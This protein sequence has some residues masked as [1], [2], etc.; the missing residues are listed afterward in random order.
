[1]VAFGLAGAVAAGIVSTK[2]PKRY[3]SI[4]VLRGDTSD[5]AKL[6]AHLNAIQKGVLNRSNLEQLIIENGLYGD[7][8]ARQPIEDILSEMRKDIFIAPVGRKG[9]HGVFRISYQGDTAD[10]AQAVTRALAQGFID[11][12]VKR[13][14]ESRR[15]GAD[16]GEQRVELL[17][18]PSIHLGESW[19]HSAAWV[20]IGLAV[21]ALIGLGAGGL[22]LFRSNS[23]KQSSAAQ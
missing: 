10:H 2:M 13:L 11:Q 5:P 8:R 21:G 4:A 22:R 1:M 15:D 23:A 18:P 19:P 17:D 6:A 9:L 7:A 3:E 12:N 20:A 14:G 16:Q